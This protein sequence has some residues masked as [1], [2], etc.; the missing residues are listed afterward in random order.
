MSSS[1]D[2]VVNVLV[3]NENDNYFIIRHTSGGFII[4]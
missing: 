2:P 1:D 3:R 4:H